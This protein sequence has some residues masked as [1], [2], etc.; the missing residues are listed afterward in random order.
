MS[1]KFQVKER[2]RRWHTYSTRIVQD[3][4][5]EWDII[6]LFL[7]GRMILKDVQK[8]TD[9]DLIVK[10]KKR[11]ILQRRFSSYKDRC[12]AVVYS[13]LHLAPLEVVAR[14]VAALDPAAVGFD[15]GQRSLLK[16]M[17]KM[18]NLIVFEPKEFMWW[19]SKYFKLSE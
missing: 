8:R 16:E 14:V 7:A 2:E 18:V 13:F 6:G 4:P 5:K 11:P 12:L 19:Y 17:E 10:G 15:Q 3:V 9:Y 1:V